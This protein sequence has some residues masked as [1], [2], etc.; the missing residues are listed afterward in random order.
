MLRPGKVV[1]H[2]MDRRFNGWSGRRGARG[3]AILFI[4]AGLAVTLG[5]AA[6][7]AGS[8]PSFARARDYATGSS[9]FSVAIGDLNG[10]RKPDLAT[11]NPGTEESAGETVSVLLN[12]GDG[13]FGPWLDY[14]TGS[15]P[16]S[17]AMGD[18]NGD[19]KPDL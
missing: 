2:S 12:N 9:P 19:R 16:I 11:A 5:V 13:T 17:V 4:C 6:L 7:F 14:G 15:R 10:D 8:G 18:L 1:T 3:C